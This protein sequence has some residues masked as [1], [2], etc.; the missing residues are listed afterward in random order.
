MVIVGSK[1]IPSAVL[2]DLFL[3]KPGGCL[4]LG[5]RVVC[6]VFT[7]FQHLCGHVPAARG[8]PMPEPG[9]DMIANYV[10]MMLVCGFCL[11]T[12]TRPVTQTIGDLP[13]AHNMGSL[14]PAHLLGPIKIACVCGT[15]WDLRPKL[16]STS[17]IRA[18]ASISAFRPNVCIQSTQE[19]I[20]QPE[21]ASQTIG[22]NTPI[23]HEI[24]F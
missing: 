18:R 10:F 12:G 24:A 15:A 19:C 14:Q 11:G 2:F 17:Q 6:N 23:K 13:H 5:F 8:E 16:S 7:Q 4:G 21:L 22:H 3:L 9:S 1:S 20:C